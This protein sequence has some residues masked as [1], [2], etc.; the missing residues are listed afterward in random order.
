MDDTD[1]AVVVCVPETADLE[2]RGEKLEPAVEAT[3]KR[4]QTH[5]ETNPA[6]ASE[7]LF[8]TDDL[9]VVVLHA[10]NA[11]RPSQDILI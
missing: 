2:R 11:R 5:V 8:E 7:E 4:N 1:L 10:H 3:Y 6:K 9:R